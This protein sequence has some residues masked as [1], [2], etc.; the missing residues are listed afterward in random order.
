MKL[1][2]YGTKCDKC[3]GKGYQPA[4]RQIDGRLES[5]KELCP[6]CKGSGTI[7]YDGDRSGV[8]WERE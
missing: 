6:E 1:A 7:Q 3:N 5:L 8:E 2:I 4:N